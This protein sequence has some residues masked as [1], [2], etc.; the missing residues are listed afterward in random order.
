[1]P[2][3]STLSLNLPSLA[4]SSHDLSRSSASPLSPRSPQLPTPTYDQDT[5]S[6]NTPAA[7][8]SSPSL[9][10]LPAPPPMSPKHR[11]IFSIHKGSRASIRP[12][13]NGHLVRQDSEKDQTKIYLSGRSPGSTHEINPFFHENASIASAASSHTED[14][15]PQA[16]RP[17]TKSS[18]SSAPHV[19]TTTLGSKRSANKPRFGILSRS[20]SIRADEGPRIKVKPST[21]VRATNGDGSTEDHTIDMGGLRTA[22][23]KEDRSFRDM[24]KSANRN[25]SADRNGTVESEDDMLTVPKDRKDSIAP[26]SF[27][28]S[29]GTGF[30]SNIRNSS[31]KAA[32]GIGKAGKGILGKL[33]RSGS[34]NEREAA[35]ED[36]YICKVINL[37]LVEQ[38]R[39]TRISK[40]LENSKDKTEFWMPALPW[41]C[42]E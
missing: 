22:P 30:L 24:M 19:P 25:R 39:R 7:Y 38:T 32:D 4:G 33:T 35:I 41:R 10:S 13:T 20:R 16:P 29:T 31:T 42:I 23:L 2:K 18:S 17:S 36:E 14:T 5:R 3:S 9:T 6:G 21:P 15:E 27:K 28:D 37:P 26:S 8:T 1:M 12:Q 40:R 11:S 34:S